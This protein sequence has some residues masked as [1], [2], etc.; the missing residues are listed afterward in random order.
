M[1]SLT[2]YYPSRAR[3]LSHSKLLYL[4]FPAL[5]LSFP[6]VSLPK[7]LNDA[8]QHTGPIFPPRSWT[9]KTRPSFLFFPWHF[10]QLYHYD[11]AELFRDRSPLPPLLRTFSSLFLHGN[12]AFF[13]LLSVF[14]QAPIGSCSGRGHCLI[15]RTE[16]STGSSPSIGISSFSE[17]E[18]E[19]LSYPEFFY[20][21]KKGCP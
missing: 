4:N 5:L 16:V 10:Y 21:L 11:V 18:V 17:K 7:V 2:V 20:L 12:A 14:Q 6:N 1:G 15:V 3:K 13:G 19:K 9:D 8:T